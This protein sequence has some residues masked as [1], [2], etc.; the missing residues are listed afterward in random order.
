MNKLVLEK[1]LRYA[2][3]L[4]NFELEKEE[5]RYLTPLISGF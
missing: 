1:D 5:F 4:L 3:G 2:N